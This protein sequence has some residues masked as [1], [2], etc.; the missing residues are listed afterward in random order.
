[1]VKEVEDALA[2]ACVW[3]DCP[4]PRYPGPEELDMLLPPALLLA[5]RVTAAGADLPV[6]GCESSP[7]MA[8]GGAD[9]A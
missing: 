2:R 3:A 7:P 1:M 4:R 8:L 9:P 5:P 6:Y